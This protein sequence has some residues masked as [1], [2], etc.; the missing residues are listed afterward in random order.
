MSLNFKRTI[1]E[2]TSKP[3]NRREFLVSIGAASLAVIG[4]SAVIKALG[5][6]DT[7][8]QTASADRSYGASAYGGNKDGR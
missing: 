1:A 3:M 4:V 8:E 7:N 5:G 2:L 6:R